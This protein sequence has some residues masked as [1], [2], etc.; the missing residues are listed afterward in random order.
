MGLLSNFRRQSA[1]EEA[2]PVDETPALDFEFGDEPAPDDDQWLQAVDRRK[3]EPSG[4]D[5]D[6]FVAGIESDVPAVAP[7]SAVPSAPLPD[8]GADAADPLAA[9]EPDVSTVAEADSDAG[10]YTI[11]N[12]AP[13]A[14]LVSTTYSEPMPMQGRPDFPTEA[15]PSPLHEQLHPTPVFESY[16]LVEPEDPPVAFAYAEELPK[17]ILEVQPVVEAGSE[18]QP[19]TLTE[20][21]ELPDLGMVFAGLSSHGIMPAPPALSVTPAP[22]QVAPIDIGFGPLG[23]QAVPLLQAMGLT[24][25]A[26]WAQ[27]TQARRTLMEQNPADGSAEQQYRRTEVNHA[28][29][30]LRLLRV[31]PLL[32]A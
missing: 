29:A 5:L 7:T 19:S 10:D 23:P 21:D 30:S 26:S 9:H 28:S 25:G 6:P 24:V 20:P 22:P 31:G 13:P 3:P 14:T 11:T 12:H 18:P 8:P 27:V 2:E 1:A 17:E 15:P 4:E 16:D 32:T